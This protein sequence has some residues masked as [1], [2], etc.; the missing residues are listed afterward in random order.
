[1]PRARSKSGAKKAVTKTSG[2][3]TSAGRKT[4]GARKKRAATET[5]TA[6]RTSSSD[7]GLICPECGKSF[8]RPASLGAHRNRAHGVSGASAR[9]VPTQAPSAGLNATGGRR[10]TAA[11]D[12]DALLAALFPN[13]IPARERVIREV[14]GWLDQAERLAKLS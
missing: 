4:S 7:A 6:R 2:R 10:S 11:V 1:M 13:G 14:N 5:A 9:R 8:S 3:K 12:R